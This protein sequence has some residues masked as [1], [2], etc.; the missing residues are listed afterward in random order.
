MEWTL[1]RSSLQDPNEA[2]FKTRDDSV[3]TEDCFEAWWVMESACLLASVACLMLITTVL[4]IHDGQLFSSWRF[5]FSLNAVVSV[6]A[7]ITRTTLI[8]AVSASLAQGK[9]IWFRK[10]NDTVNMF[11]IIDSA[12]RETL[13]SF[14]LLWH[15]KGR[16]NKSRVCERIVCALTIFVAIL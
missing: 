7:A 11:E 5:Y 10:R 6:L 9:W 1:T 4:K 3:S 14:K 2:V 13:G 12:S 15:T 8:V 16:Y